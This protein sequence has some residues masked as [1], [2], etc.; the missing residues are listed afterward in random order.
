MNQP[1]T[2]KFGGTYGSPQS[3]PLNLAQPSS[4]NAKSKLLVGVADAVLAKKLTSQLKGAAAEAMIMTASSLAQFTEIS[5]KANPAVIF[6]DTDLLAG[7]SISEAVQ[8]FS[9]NAPL[10]LLTPVNKQVEIAK[11]ISSNN[12]DFIGRVGD[13]MP[14]ASALIERRLRKSQISSIENRA[15]PL[16]LE[17]LGELFRH[18][19]NNPLTG[20]LGNTELVL[21]HRENLSAI[22]VQ[23]LQ[24]VVDL[25]VRLRESIRRFSNEHEWPA[26]ATGAV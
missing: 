18:E 12:V 26:P 4:C 3:I 15:E 6:L 25:A 1:A 13:F 20:I 24:T 23:R 14:V 10:I 8:E 2:K 5:A 11:V 9:K 17:N 21:A 16:S 7:R 19:I 22:D